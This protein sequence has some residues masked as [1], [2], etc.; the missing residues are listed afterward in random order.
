MGIKCRCPICG[1]ND[2]DSNRSRKSY[3]N[4]GLGYDERGPLLPKKVG[5]KLRRKREKIFWKQEG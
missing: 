1:R 4:A 3:I 2:P 5:R